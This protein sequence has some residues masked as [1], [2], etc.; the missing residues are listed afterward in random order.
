M[1]PDGV[2]AEPELMWL[3]LAQD[4]V[5]AFTAPWCVLCGAALETGPGDQ[6]R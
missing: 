6:A 1:V 3:G 4:K 2:L 5:A